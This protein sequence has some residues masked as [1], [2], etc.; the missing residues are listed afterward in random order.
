SQKLIDPNFADLRP[1]K[2][3][4][5]MYIG[6]YNSHVLGFDNI[7]RIKPDDADVLARISTGIGYAKRAMRTN[8]D[9]FMM[10]VCRP[11]ILNGI[12]AELADRADLADRSIVLDLP[13]L[14]EDRQ[15]FEEEFW[16][17]FEK[18]KPFILGALLGGVVGAM[19]AGEID[20]SGYGR[21]RMMDFARFA[22]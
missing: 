20:I 11:I 13:D 6:A 17:D 10:R 8:A 9:Q 15:R 18:T 19:K 2:S 12:P 7:S 4:D 3:E 22:E 16:A 14:L 5:D 1:F 21:F